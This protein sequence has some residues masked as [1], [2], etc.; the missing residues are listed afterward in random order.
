MWNKHLTANQKNSNNY[1]EEAHS[2]NK[3]SK[4]KPIA[5]SQSFNGI[6]GSRW[7]FSFVIFYKNIQ[8]VIQTIKIMNVYDVRFD[9]MLIYH[10]EVKNKR[11]ILVSSL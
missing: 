8:A 4:T 10:D 6:L 2:Y 9:K 1:K 3:K 5:S 7:L 11:I